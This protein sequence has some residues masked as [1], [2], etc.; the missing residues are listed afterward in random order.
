MTEEFNLSKKLT[1]AGE[2][3]NPHK[4][5]YDT[6]VFLKEDVKEF[7]RLLKEDILF[8]GNNQDTNVVWLLQRL[9]KLA[10]EKLIE[11]AKA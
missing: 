5:F 7:I 3:Y 10:G 8:V 1:L 4:S 11:G 2:H 6:E 9:D